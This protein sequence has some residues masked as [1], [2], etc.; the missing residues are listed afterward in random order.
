[1]LSV[2]AVLTV[3]VEARLIAP[4]DR[5]VPPIVPDILAPKL[6]T[7]PPDRDAPM[8]VREIASSPNTAAR[9]RLL[10]VGVV[11]RDAAPVLKL[12]RPN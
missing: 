6:K 10:A 8:R 7:S 3:C 11:G 9:D 4:L 12:K 1:M 2:K 5:F